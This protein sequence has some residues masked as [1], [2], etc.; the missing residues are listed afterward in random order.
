MILFPNSLSIAAC[1]GVCITSMKSF[2]SMTGKLG[3]GSGVS[4]KKVSVSQR[5]PWYH[6]TLWLQ[7]HGDSEMLLYNKQ[8]MCCAL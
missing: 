4:P 2:S 5:H 6:C 8:V 1:R 3:S 7:V